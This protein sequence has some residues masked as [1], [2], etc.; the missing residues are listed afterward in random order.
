MWIIYF[1]EINYVDHISMVNANLQKLR[2]S[3]YMGNLHV[4]TEQNNYL[5]SF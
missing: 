1:L 5:Q 2:F 3:F 4:I